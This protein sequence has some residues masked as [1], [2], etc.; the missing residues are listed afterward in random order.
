[1]QYR[2]GS[3]HRK[4]NMIIKDDV[5]EIELLQARLKE[6]EKENDYLKA[7]LQAEGIDYSSAVQISESETKSTFVPNQGSRVIPVEIT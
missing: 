5:I 4:V 2:N 7:L 3:G 6:L 1:M